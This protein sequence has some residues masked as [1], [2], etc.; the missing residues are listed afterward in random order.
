MVIKFQYFTFKSVPVSYS[1][2]PNRF[3]MKFTFRLFFLQILHFLMK[4]ILN[5]YKNPQK[6]AKF[7]TFCIFS[8]FQHFFSLQSSYFHCTLQSLSRFTSWSFVSSVFMQRKIIIS[9][10]FL[11]WRQT[12]SAKISSTSE[13]INSACDVF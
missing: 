3:F 11:C 7:A 5:P 2:C 12:H 1:N 6:L 8:N 10:F 13:T 4:L 9:L